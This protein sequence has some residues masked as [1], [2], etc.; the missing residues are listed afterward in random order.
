M[1]SIFFL[2]LIGGLLTSCDRSVPE[3]QSSSLPSVK[4]AIHVG[5]SHFEP[6]LRTMIKPRLPEG[7]KRMGITGPVVMEIKI[8][9]AG[10]VLGSRVIRG[11]TMLNDAAED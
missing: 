1:M 2:L 5:V 4:P 11:H 8:D 10:N 9:Q 6:K 3:Q 7:A